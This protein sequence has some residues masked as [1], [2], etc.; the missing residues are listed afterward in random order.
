[1]YRTIVT[2]VLFLFTWTADACT[3]FMINDGQHVWI[4]NNED[5][6]PG[7][8]YR[9]WYYPAK[10]GDYGYMIWSELAMG[11]LFYGLMY[12]NPQGGLN[13]HGLFMDYTA[14]D[15]VPVVS[16]PQKKNRKKQV[17]TDI[18]KRCKTVD[19]A[20][21]YISKYNLVKLNSAQL[22]IGDAQG[23]YAT[24]TGG[25]VLRKTDNNFALTNYCIKDHKEAC[26]RR[27]FATA[28][29]APGKTY[30][31]DDVRNILYKT[32]Q[33]RPSNIIT[34]FSMAV[35]L[36]AATIHLYNKNDTT[37]AVVLALKQEL[38]KGKH[39]K[40][41]TRYFPEDIA[42]LLT[43]KYF[44]SGIDAA[45]DEYKMLRKNNPG[46]YNFK[47]NEALNLAIPL[48]EQGRTGDAVKFLETLKA[49]DP[50]KP[51]IYT[52]LG[53]AYRKENNITASDEHFSKALTLKPGDYL[54]TL[55]GRQENQKVIFKMDDFEAAE[56]V[57]MIADFTQWKPVA[58]EKKNGVWTYEAVIPRGEHNY[59]FLVNKE[60]LADQINLMYTGSG[61]QIF[62]KLYVW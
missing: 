24:V 6:A 33:K 25:Y 23:N 43:E 2:A 16:E 15:E 48:I 12:L 59:K 51:D 34:N 17:V 62:S 27:D 10:R 21:A 39:H 1:M 60:Y 45:I 44:K 7:T 52:W 56:Q 53:V 50:D 47:N 37:V 28:Y 46:Q 26:W 32:S 41:L 42:P 54:A 61:P 11:K 58:F 30:T 19:E 8:N 38:G 31:L 9:M 13:E 3:I 35:D 55:W 4:G 14:I 40:D 18:L 57:S 49:Y 5:E 36:K 20:L 29:W 22:F